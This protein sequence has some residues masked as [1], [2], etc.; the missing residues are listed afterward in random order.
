MAYW[1]PFYP[2]RTLYSD[3]RAHTEN[4]RRFKNATTKW[5]VISITTYVGRFFLILGGVV[6]GIWYEVHHDLTKGQAFLVCLVV[7]LPAI[8]IWFAVEHVA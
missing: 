4:W 6:L 2:T 7:L 5:P 3:V 1:D 8:L